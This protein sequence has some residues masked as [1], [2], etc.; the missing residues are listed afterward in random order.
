MFI[1]FVIGISSIFHCLGMCGPLAMAM[2]VNR[3]SRAT[4]FSSAMQYHFG[5]VSSYFLLGLLMGC[6]GFSFVSIRWMQLLSIVFGLV[7]IG[8][9][10]R[11]FFYFA[12]ITQ[13]KFGRFIL[14]FLG[15]KMSKLM[16]SDRWFRLLLLGFLNGL[17]PC[18]MVYIALANALLQETPLLGG[19]SMMMFGI[20]TMPIL[21]VL[22]VLSSKI[23]TRWKERFSSYVPYLMT[24]VGVMI[25][26][27]GMNIGIPYISPKIKS[28][29]SEQMLEDENKSPIELID[30]HP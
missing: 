29:V 24:V 1:G 28:F 14:R 7:V 30:C 18:G 16:R 9:A 13:S 6:I 8:L 26:L 2:P 23:T 22:I 25:V 12:K 21:S 15:V 17:L 11:R 3:T 4:L 19:I 27:R 10:W 5:R 20:G